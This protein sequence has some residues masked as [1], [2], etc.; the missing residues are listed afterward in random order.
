MTSSPPSTLAIRSD[1]RALA[2]PI[3]TV[4]DKVRVSRSFDVD[5]ARENP[6]GSGAGQAWVRTPPPFAGRATPAGRTRPRRGARGGRDRRGRRARETR[7][8]PDPPARAL[9]RAWRGRPR[10]AAPPRLRAG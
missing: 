7:R 10:R 6:L 4:S 9:G 3:L 5:G 8:R 2:S 1:R